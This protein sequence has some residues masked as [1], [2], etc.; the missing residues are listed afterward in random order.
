MRNCLVIDLDRCT[1]CR[2]CEVACKM[3]NG[4]GLGVYWNKVL[5]VGPAGT[6]PDIEQYWLP[7]H[8]QQCEDAPCVKVCPTGASYRDPKTN[9]VLIDKAKCIG[10]KYC[11]IACPYGVRSFNEAEKVVEKCTLCTQLTS[12]GEKPACVH[13]CA[14]GARFY[15]DLDDADSDASKAIADAGED[16]VYLL[17]DAGNHPATRYIMH[18][19][20]ATWREG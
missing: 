4:V 3:E 7:A 18:K 5:T 14:T 13:N 17:P 19:K 9:I 15:G 6:F 2:S 16:N 20:T 10:C 12:A 1:G 11:M 8:C